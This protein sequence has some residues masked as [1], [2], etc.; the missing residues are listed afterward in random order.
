MKAN[1]FNISR[2]SFLK[3]CS[4]TAAATGLPAW[5]VQRELLAAAVRP[6]S[7]GSNDRPG[8]ALVGC[9]GMG[10]GDATKAS[11]LGDILAVCDVDDKHADQAVKQFTKDGKAPAKYNDFRKV[12]ER[13]D[14]HIIL[15]C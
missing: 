6:K 2:R 9:G 1:P 5:F 14:I 10:R 4:L 8:I 12:M 15:T 3:T 13:D 7:L 11:S